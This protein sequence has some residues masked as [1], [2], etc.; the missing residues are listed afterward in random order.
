MHVLVSEETGMEHPCQGSCYNVDVNV[1][2]QFW[3][4]SVKRVLW[5]G[6]HFLTYFIYTEKFLSNSKI[7]TQK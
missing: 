7:K 1:S 6:N 3:D 2:F 4:G 5:T